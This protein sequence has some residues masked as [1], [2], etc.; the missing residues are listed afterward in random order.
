MKKLAKLYRQSQENAKKCLRR[1][2]KSWI[3]V[4][5]DCTTA[6]PEVTTSSGYSTSTQRL[7]TNMEN[8]VSTTPEYNEKVNKTTVDSENTTPS[9]NQQSHVLSKKL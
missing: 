5:V 7:Q 6:R 2:N 9:D 8:L 1:T 4:V 3:F